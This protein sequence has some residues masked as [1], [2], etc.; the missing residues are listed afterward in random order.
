[1][2]IT[3]IITITMMIVMMIVLIPIDTT[4]SGMLTVVRT[5]QPENEY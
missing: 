3:I 4:P 2:K 5:L 1:M